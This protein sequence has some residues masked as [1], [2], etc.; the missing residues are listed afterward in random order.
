MSALVFLLVACG[1]GGAAGPVTPTADG[2]EPPVALDIP[3]I[4]V[5]ADD[6]QMYG[7]AGTPA[8]GDPCP[9]DPNVV[10]WDALHSQPGKPGL[11]R[12]VASAHGAFRRLGDVGPDDPIVVTRADGTRATFTRSA[13]VAD[14]TARTPELQLSACDVSFAAVV[15]AGLV[16]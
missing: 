10:A 1:T 8:A 2:S 3:A 7:Y 16:S 15:Y 6:L 5:H 11:A 9:R 13:S 14:P 12:L 4:G